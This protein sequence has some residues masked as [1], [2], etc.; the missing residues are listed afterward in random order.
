MIPPPKKTKQVHKFGGTC[1]SAADRIASATELMV[2]QL[3]KHSKEDPNAAAAVVVSAMGAHPSSPVKVTDLLLSVISKAA[4][5]DPSYS[6]DLAA[7]R[8]KH[9]ETADELLLGGG[10]GGGGG[11]TP[12]EGEGERDAFVAS[13][14]A[15]VEDLRAVLQAISIAGVSSTSGAFADFV[16]GHGELWCARLFAATLRVRL[17]ADAGVLDAREVLVVTPT[18]DGTS[19]DVEYAPS[20]AALDAWGAKEVETRRKRDGDGGAGGGAPR[21]RSRLPRVVVVTGFVA[22]TADGQPTTLRRNGSDYSATIVG[23]LFKASSIV[24]WTDVDGVFSADP[25]K[26]GEAVCLES[27]SYQEAWELAYFGASVLHPRTTQPAMR[28]NI[29]VSIRNFFNL[30]APGTVI[31][32]DPVPAD[33]AAAVAAKKAAAASKSGKKKRST[34]A[35]GD[36]MVK[37]FATIDGIALINV[38]GT[39]MVSTGVLSFFC[40]CVRGGSFRI[41]PFFLFREFDVDD[42]GEKEKKLT[43]LFSFAFPLPKSSSSSSSSSTTTTTPQVGVPGVASTIFTTVRDAAC[44]VVMISQASSEHSICFAVKSEEADR[45]LGALRARFADAIAAG[46]ISAV[47]C[48]RDCAVLAAVGRLMCERKG[49]AA[50]M[51]SALA[52]AN[53]NI[54]SI[55]QGCSEYNVTVLVDEKDSV[56]ALRAVHGRFYL[57]TL[58][59]AVAVV[60][61]GLIGRTFLEQV[62]EQASVLRDEFDIDV[63]VLGIAS[64]TRM[65]LSDAGIDPAKWA[66]ALASPETSVPADLTALGKHLANNYIPNCVIVDATASASPPEHYLEWMKASFEV[67]WVSVFWF[68]SGKVKRERERERESGERRRESGET[69]GKKD[70]RNSLFFLLLF[71]L[72]LTTFST[73]KQAGIHVITPN[74]KLNSGPLE[75]YSALRQFQR[76]S[77]IH[78]LYEVYDVFFKLFKLSPPP[79]FSLPLFPSSTATTKIE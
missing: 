70:A 3:E 44:N 56:R 21:P 18:P 24:I 11:G 63:R 9:V 47:D 12:G 23:A 66:E 61:P 62:A 65:A 7:L 2:S 64:S 34:A 25:R 17:G 37:G 78:Y 71:S 76:E 51:F 46:R 73:N 38:E 53:V 58:P 79:S 27:L 59:L 35:G 5:R 10:G 77:Y 49:V 48:I 33:A 28:S 69:K 22:R 45:A 39:G 15:D 50:T 36:G 55:A 67:F 20:E 40:V 74:K 42:A 6:E 30:S 43:S 68:R 14:D 32:A 52:K 16:V 8:A 31:C 4:S 13:V 60:G 75:Q 1:V 41:F 29:P 57:A 72:Y 54:R 26:V 19:V